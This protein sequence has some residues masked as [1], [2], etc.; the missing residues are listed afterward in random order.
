MTA[1]RKFREFFKKVYNSYLLATISGL[2]LGVS[3]MSKFQDTKMAVIACLMSKRSEF[4]VVVGEVVE[5][6]RGGCGL[7]ALT[8]R[9]SKSG[10]RERLRS[11]RRSASQA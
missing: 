11:V 6:L 2:G 1:K 3:K 5:M 9:R 4:A 8:R 10:L 7:T